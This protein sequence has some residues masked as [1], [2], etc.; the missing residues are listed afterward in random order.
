MQRELGRN[1]VLDVSYL[2]SEG[3]KLPVGWNIN[4]AVPGATGT[5]NSRRPYQGYGSITGG[6]IS[7]IGNSNFHAMQ[8]RAERRFSRGLSFVSSYTF[9]KSIDDNAGISTGSDSSGN[10]QDARNL[11]AERG[12]SDYDVHHRWVLSYV[13]DLPFGKGMLHAPSNPLLSAIVGG[14]QINGILTMQ[15]GRPFTVLSGTDVSNT[16]G[17]NDRPNVVGDWSVSNQ[18]PDSWF[19]PAAFT[20]ATAGTFGNAGRNILRG[21]TLKNFDLGVSRTFRI[22][23]RQGLQLRTE[24]F[25]LTNHPNFFFPVASLSSSAIGRIQRANSQAT[26]GA[27][28]QIQFGL[29]YSF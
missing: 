10:A 1:F 23:E 2:G 4:Q 7:S 24:F 20:R 13:Y 9:S 3:H 15:G 27:Q 11:R 18:G 26:T 14:W 16:G 19:N 21:P 22:T 12:L 28:R 8:V 29:K 17:N 6:F 5:V 25:N